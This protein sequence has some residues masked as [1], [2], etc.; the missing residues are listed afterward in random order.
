MGPTKTEPRFGPRAGWPTLGVKHACSISS[1]QGPLERVTESPKEGLGT[2]SPDVTAAVAMARPMT[3]LSLLSPSPAS[4]KPPPP[5]SPSSH[6]VFTVFYC[7][8][9]EK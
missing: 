9:P 2:C 5:P 8:L 6:M 4:F 3:D 7:S 1:N